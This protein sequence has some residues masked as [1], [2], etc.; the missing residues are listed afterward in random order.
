MRTSF[1]SSWIALLLCTSLMLT[2]GLTLGAQGQQQEVGA[3]VQILAAKVQAW[4][5]FRL[6][7]IVGD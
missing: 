4:I 3:L 6:D 2:P 1:K 7:Q 5:D